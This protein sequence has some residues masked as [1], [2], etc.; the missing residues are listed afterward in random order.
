VFAESDMISKPQVR[1][2]ERRYHQRTLRGSRPQLHE[3]RRKGQDARTAVRV[4]GRGRGEQGIIAAFEKE[5]GHPSS[6][7]NTTG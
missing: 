1:V 3:Q 6:S 7:R 5:L 4:P 2:L